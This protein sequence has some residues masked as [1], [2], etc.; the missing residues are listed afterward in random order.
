MTETFFLTVRIVDSYL[1]V[2][3]VTRNKLQLVGVTSLWIAAKYQ[4]TYQVPKLTNL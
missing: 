1:R 2:A 4:E 3:R